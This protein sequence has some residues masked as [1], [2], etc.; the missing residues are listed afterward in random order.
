MLNFRIGIGYD[1]HQLVSGRPLILGGVD[2]P[3]DAGLLGHS[4][5]DV[6]AHVLID[7]ILGAA[8]MGSIGT[9]F[10]NTDSAYA[11]VRSVDLLSQVVEA[12]H[13]R[14][15]W[16]GNIDMTVVAQAPKLMPYVPDMVAVLARV[17]HVDPARVSIKATTTEGLGFEGEKR[18]ISAHCVVLIYET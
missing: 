16:V 5:A 15:F 1:A 2:I 13:Q 9:W 6:V 7:A 12:L 18:G 3:H 10:P 4:D 14:G 11:G 17:T 8:N